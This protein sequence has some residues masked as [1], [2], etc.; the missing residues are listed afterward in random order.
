MSYLQPRHHCATCSCPPP[1]YPATSDVRYL[2]VDLE[3][4]VTYTY[5]NG[6]SL[7]HHCMK[8]VR[9][10]PEY[11]F[12]DSR[13]RRYHGMLRLGEARNIREAVRMLA[14]ARRDWLEAETARHAEVLRRK[15]VDRAPA[16]V[17]ALPRKKELILAE[18]KPC[19]YC[20]MDNP[21]TIDHIVPWRRGGGHGRRNLAPACGWCNS[22]KGN[23]TP[24]EW[25]EDR[26]KRGLCWPPEP[27]GGARSKIDARLTSRSVS[28][29]QLRALKAAS[30]SGGAELREFWL[31]T[32][33]ALKRAGWIE[34]IRP[35]ACTYVLTDRGRLALE[36]GRVPR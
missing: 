28:D 18:G 31:T 16:A 12:D 24:K 3:R 2:P 14:V 32:V 19:A 21:R 9:W 27:R 7:I 29:A 20:G 35:H 36:S 23:R 30:Q 13:Y 17:R 5:R 6:T 10:E 11:A 33:A 4:Q 22:E 25:R 15:Y 34:P 1:Q 26:L 8:F